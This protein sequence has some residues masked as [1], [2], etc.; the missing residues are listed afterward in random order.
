MGVTLALGILA[1]INDLNF[2]RKCYTTGRTCLHAIRFCDLPP[3]RELLFAPTRGALHDTNEEVGTARIWAARPAPVLRCRCGGH[4]LLACTVICFSSSFSY[5]LD[6]D[7]VWHPLSHVKLVAPCIQN[8]QRRQASTVAGSPTNPKMDMTFT[9][10]GCVRPVDF[11]LHHR[12]SNARPKL[13][14]WRVHRAGAAEYHHHL[15]MSLV[16]RYMCKS[17]TL[18]SVRMSYAKVV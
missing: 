12:A 3:G 7:V 6:R 11:I 18:L 2:G 10:M 1:D 17:E 4:A 14:S 9:R 8:V 16:D 5:L 15:D 13:D